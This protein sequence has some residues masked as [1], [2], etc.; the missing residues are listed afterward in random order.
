MMVQ[1]HSSNLMLDQGLSACTFTMTFL[2]LRIRVRLYK[3]SDG[4]LRNYYMGDFILCAGQ[5]NIRQYGHPL[6]SKWS[7]ILTFGQLW[8]PSPNLFAKCKYTQSALVNVLI[9]VFKVDLFIKTCF[10]PQCRPL[11]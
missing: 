1:L 6:W 10:C 9:N 4:T 8:A 7:S 5:I 2:R 3:D 11:Y